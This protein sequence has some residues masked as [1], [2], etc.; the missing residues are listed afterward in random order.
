MP[1]KPSFKVIAFCNNRVLFGHL[2]EVEL[3]S[4]SSINSW[5]VK[6]LFYA[7]VDCDS[8][9]QM[10]ASPTTV[11]EVG[12]WSS[13]IWNYNLIE[14]VLGLLKELDGSCR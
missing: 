11:V 8:D 2:K 10:W 4:A 5:G 7:P 13:V 9:T 1:D 6:G 14:A 12:Q 3:I